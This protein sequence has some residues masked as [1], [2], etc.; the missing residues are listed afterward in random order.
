VSRDPVYEFK[1]HRTLYKY[2]PDIISKPLRRIGRKIFLKRYPKGSLKES[3]KKYDLVKS[4][5]K[6]VLRLVSSNIRRIRKKFPKFSHNDLHIGNVLIHGSKLLFTDFELCSLN[7]KPRKV[8]KSYGITG[9][10]PLY[11]FHCF[12]NSLR[13]WC[14]KNKKKCLVKMLNSIVPKGYRGVNGKYIRNCRLRA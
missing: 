13:N 10:K 5:M 7:G 12:T 2:F 6:T 11:D 9:F 1:T 8:I 14:V 3:V 4:Q